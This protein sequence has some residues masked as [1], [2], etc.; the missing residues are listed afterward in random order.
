MIKYH[1]M[2]IQTSDLRDGCEDHAN[3]AAARFEKL[4]GVRPQVVLQKDVDEEINRYW[5][6]VWIWDIAP[7]DA[8]Y[9]LCFDSKILPMRKLP[10]LPDLKFAAAMD[11][12]DRVNQ[13]KGRSPTVAASGKCFQMQLFIAHRD[14][15]PVFEELKRLGRTEKY[16]T[17]DGVPDETG[18][19][20]R[21][22]FTP[23]NDLIQSNFDV[24]ELT[25]AWNWIIT[26]EKQYYFASPYM[27]NFNG[28]EYGAWSYL[29]YIRSLAERIEALGGTLDGPLEDGWLGDRSSDCAPR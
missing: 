26:Y 1:P 11:R 7:D 18:Y 19:D 12:H 2:I 24:Y 8:E 23:L 10:E 25:R 13:T 29:K 27:I 21:I 3:A 20:Q 15:R 6:P 5:Y 22:Y 9:I 17:R 28:N 4:N 16:N 14:T